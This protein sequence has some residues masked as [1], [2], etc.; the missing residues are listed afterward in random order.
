MQETP[1]SDGCARKQNNPFGAVQEVK[2]PEEEEKKQHHKG[3]HGSDKFGDREDCE[4]QKSGGGGGDG[5]G[6]D[7]GDGGESGDDEKPRAGR[8]CNQEV[9]EEDVEAVGAPSST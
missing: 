8:L 4:V 7:G 1:G 9:K 5:S 3:L 6:N 2:L